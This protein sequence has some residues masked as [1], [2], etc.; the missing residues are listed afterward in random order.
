MSICESIRGDKSEQDG[1]TGPEEVTL[2]V[3]GVV[4]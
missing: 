3:C 4:R 1:V 2:L